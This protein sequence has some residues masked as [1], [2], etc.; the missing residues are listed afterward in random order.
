MS[1]NFRARAERRNAA[2]RDQRVAQGAKLCGDLNG[3][4]SQRTIE[5]PAFTAAALVKLEVINLNVVPL[6]PL[7]ALRVKVPD[8]F[9]IVF[10]LSVNVEDGH[11]S[12][13]ST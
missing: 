4:N 1:S 8:V 13:R 2:T 9:E 7:G 3:V 5:L 11:E 10:A 6:R 12:D